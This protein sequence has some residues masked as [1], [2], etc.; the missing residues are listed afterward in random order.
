MKI[1][2]G[3]NPARDG[4]KYIRID[5]DY[6]DFRRFED[7]LRSTLMHNLIG[8]IMNQSETKELMKYLVNG[9]DEAKDDIK[10]TIIDRISD[11][12]IEDWRLGDKN[13]QFQRED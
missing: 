9:I 5:Y 7:E 8:Y 10:K 13:E 1:F 12:V 2:S 3:E 4:S 11:A 6:S